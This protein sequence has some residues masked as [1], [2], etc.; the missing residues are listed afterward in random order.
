[1]KSVSSHQTAVKACSDKTYKLTDM[2]CIFS[3]IIS[4]NLLQQSLKVSKVSYQA[5]ICCWFLHIF[6]FR[7]FARFK[8][9]WLCRGFS[10]LEW[11]DFLWTTYHILLL[12]SLYFLILVINKF[13]DL[14]FLGQDWADHAV[15]IILWGRGYESV[16]ECV[17]L[18][19]NIDL[20]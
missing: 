7:L 1:M 2:N 13:Q 16:A 12:Y 14:T 20:S 6:H 18:N 15:T 10:Q 19:R 8:L 9:P 3:S 11:Q 5:I 17:L 4:I